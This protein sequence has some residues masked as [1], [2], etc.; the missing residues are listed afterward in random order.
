[1]YYLQHPDDG[2]IETCRSVSNIW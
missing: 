2:A 1:L